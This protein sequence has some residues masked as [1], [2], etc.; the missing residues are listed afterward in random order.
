MAAK[1]MV[2]FDCPVQYQ[3]WA[4]PMIPP[5][6]EENGVEVDDPGRCYSGDHSEPVE[7]DSHHGGHEELKKTFDPEVNDPKRQWSA[8][9]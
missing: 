3:W 1:A 2:I 6:Q 5:P 8:T 9:E 4:V 7:Q